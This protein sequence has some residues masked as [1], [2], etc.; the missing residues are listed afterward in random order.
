MEAQR[1]EHDSSLYKGIKIRQRATC[2]GCFPA[3]PPVHAGTRASHTMTLSWNIFYRMIF[4]LKHIV[5]SHH[6][7]QR[8]ELH[9]LQVLFKPPNDIWGAAREEWI[10]AAKTGPGLGRRLQIVSRSVQEPAEAPDLHMGQW[11]EKTGASKCP[12]RDR[13]H[14]WQADSLK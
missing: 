3:F 9:R 4:L 11:A 12:S 2:A 1:Q 13:Q 7:C 10:D 5:C 6:G 8:G 14:Y